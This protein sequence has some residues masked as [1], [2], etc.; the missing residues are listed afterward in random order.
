M[1]AFFRQMGT[2][3]QLRHVV[4]IAVERALPVVSP[5]YDG[6]ASEDEIRTRWRRYYAGL[7]EDGEK[8]DAPSD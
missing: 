2:T 3:S 8:G 7:R 6:G 1:V 4:L 5:G